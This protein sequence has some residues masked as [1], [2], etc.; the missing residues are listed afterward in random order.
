M[1]KIEKTVKM[2]KIEKIEKIEKMVKI[3]KMIKNIFQ[4]SK[5]IFFF[6]RSF[7]IFISEAF[8]YA[9]IRD[10]SSFI[11]RLTM[12]L[13]SINI[14]YVKIFQAVALNNRL[15]DDKINNKLLKFT[16]N[17]PWNYSDIDFMDLI[18]MTN[19]YGLHLKDGYEVP[20]NSGM[21][22]LVF[23]AYKDNDMNYPVIIKMK[24]KNI[25]KKLDDAINNIL[26]IM[27]FL[28]FI[29]IIDKYQLA[30]VVNKNIEI[31]RNQTNFLEEVN[32]MEL[33]R[34]NCKNLKYVKIPTA[35]KEVTEEYP[36][37]IVMEYI[38][39]N[40]INQIKDEDYEG[41]AKQIVKFGIVTTIIHGIA[42]GD[43]HSGNILFIKDDND[44]RYPH[45]IGVI[46]FG[47][48]Y[49]VGNKYKNLLFDIFTQLFEL[50]PL[51]IAEK[52]LNSG[53]IE[54]HGIL[55]QIPKEHYIHI[56]KFTEEILSETING[57][58]KA[59]QIQ[60]YKFMSKMKDYLSKEELSRIGVRPSD[61]FIKSQ[62]VLAMAHGVTLTLCKY[63]FITL[64]DKCL[65]ELF[66]TEILFT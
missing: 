19:K 27:Y 44:L 14:L 66:R 7:F 35:N 23:K 41:F 58:K 25:Q 50:T 40:K 63:D 46:D 12:R 49:K 51:E 62:L 8:L 36:N 11:E 47:I 53:I 29:P 18:E 52:F 37:F 43:L 13:S 42:H 65:N 31:V 55:Q 20:I 21:I 16:D 24:R 32:N 6:V 28:S 64:M 48:I 17:A 59:N 5:G 4:N 38:E 15:I 61:D 34:E 54:P 33:M 30:D 45:K 1:E 3:E 56:I 26:F 9:F 57:S 60:A 39:G 10:Y 2:V 22:S